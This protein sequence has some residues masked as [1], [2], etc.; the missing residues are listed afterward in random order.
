MPNPA[1]GFRD[2]PDHSMSLSAADR[3]VRVSLAGVE[4]ARSTRAIRL[5]EASYPP[6]YYIPQADIDMSKLTPTPHATYCPFKGRA[7]YWSV[8]AG[9]ETSENAAWAY[10]AP[11]D[12][13]AAIRGMIAFYG[14][15][16]EI[17]A[18]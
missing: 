11:Y 3:S 16:F 1:P 10:E 9:G 7:G 2:R 8:S 5:D 13:C 14:D 4:I 12:E 6:R 15:E 17:E 18:G